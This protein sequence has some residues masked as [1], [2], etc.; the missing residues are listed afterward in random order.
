[1]DDAQKALKALTPRELI[2]LEGATGRIE[3]Q[4]RNLTAAAAAAK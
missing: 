2:S 3:V 1:M 4:L